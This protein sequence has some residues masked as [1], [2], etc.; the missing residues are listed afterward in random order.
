MHRGA[1]CER[2]NAVL[3]GPALPLPAPAS[4]RAEINWKLYR[5][6]VVNCGRPTRRSRRAC[7]ERLAS[8]SRRRRPAQAVCSPIRSPQ[9]ERSRRLRAERARSSMLNVTVRM[10]V[11][12][13][14]TSLPRRRQHLCRGW[15]DAHAQMQVVLLSDLRRFSGVACSKRIFR[16]CS[17]R[18]LV[19]RLCRIGRAIPSPPILRRAR[20]PRSRAT[21][22]SSP[23]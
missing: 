8:K 19:R 16:K 12:S 20:S 22:R 17:F 5:S 23:R 13:S 18:R 3:V 21:Y 6:S 1:K 4:G 9:A 11:A 14:H 2:G 15:R 10:F 7:Q